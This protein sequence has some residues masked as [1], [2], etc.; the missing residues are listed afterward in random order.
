MVLPVIN[1]SQN[2]YLFDAN[3]SKTIKSQSY[4]YKIPWSANVHQWLCAAM[5][6]MVALSQSTFHR[7]EK[8]K[9]WDKARHRRW[10][11][12][13][14]CF[15]F[16]LKKNMDE[17]KHFSFSA[18]GLHCL[19]SP[20]YTNVQW[21]PEQ[22]HRRNATHSAVIFTVWRKKIRLQTFMWILK[23]ARSWTFLVKLQKPSAS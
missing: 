18:L 14:V 4:L 13:S 19:S 16:S 1:I 2:A 10:G 11:V 5:R 8:Q 3:Y 6:R 22:L 9:V 20:Y 7:R 12:L 15:V 17:G 21:F 23:V